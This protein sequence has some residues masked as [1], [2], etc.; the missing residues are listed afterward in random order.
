MIK[1][2]IRALDLLHERADQ[3][4]DE[5]LSKVVDLLHARL[6]EGAQSLGLPAA[7][8]QSERSGGDPKTLAAPGTGD[9]LESELDG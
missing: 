6:A 9:A 8:L 5:R 3:L 2:T 7:M 1:K 4:G